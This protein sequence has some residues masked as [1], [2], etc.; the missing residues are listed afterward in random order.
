MPSLK[1]LSLAVV[2][3]LAA[4][5]PVFAQLSTDEVP[6]HRTVPKSEEIQDQL[7]D[8]RWHLG[9]I[10]LRPIFGLR[11]AGYNDNVFGS[12][13]D[14]VADWGGTVSAGADLLLPMGRKLYLRGTAN[15]QYTW[16]KKVASRR[17]MGGVY[18]GSILGLFNHLLIETGGSSSKTILPI[19][20]EVERATP[21]QQTSLFANT[22]VDVFERL[23]VFGSA[24]RLKQRYESGGDLL[25]YDPGQ[26]ERDETYVQGGLRYKPRSYFDVSIAAENAR[27]EFVTATRNDNQSTAIVG[28]IHYDRP[29]LFIALSAGNRRI[30]PR[31]AF[32]SFP[33][34]N[35]PIGSYFATA[36][37][38]VP[39]AIDVYGHRG[40]M[41]SLLSTDRYFDETR[42]GIGGTVL[43]GRRLG[44]RAFTERGSNR[45][46]LV[47]TS[48]LRR[49]DN[50]SIVGGGIAYRVYRNIVVMFIASDTR[51][52][53]NFDTFDRS[54]FRLGA[55]LS[56]TGDMFQ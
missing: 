25:D 39:L 30:E 42:N 12:I 17:M 55:T 56:L 16:Y 44:L 13:D 19:N 24:E 27:T 51:Y 5:L 45:Y 53:S 47:A 18:G 32:S 6:Q 48:P 29:R 14:P 31:G 9:A 22:E 20:S 10:R 46:S 50:V 43:F 3:M 49:N 23:A 41:Y 34:F 8:S 28:G 33:A 52:D 38:G 35:A 54:I 7:N 36:Q 1:R 11:D 21:G 40:I 2:T 15:P 26:L 37:L 4:S